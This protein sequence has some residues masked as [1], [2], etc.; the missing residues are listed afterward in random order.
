MAGPDRSREH[1]RLAVASLVATVSLA[2][3]LCGN[4]YEE[5]AVVMSA[6]HDSIYA[7]LWNPKRVAPPRFRWMDDRTGYTSIV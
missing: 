6:K 1:D 5:F 2:A 3:W 4:A 7:P